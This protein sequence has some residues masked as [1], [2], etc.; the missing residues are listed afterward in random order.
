MASHEEFQVSIPSDT[1][2]GQVV[3]ERIVELLE[4]FEY[5]PR[6]VFG[7]RLAL[8]EALVNSIK[9]GNQMDSSKQVHIGCHIDHEQVVVTIEDEGE[10]FKIE[11]IP[12]P[13][14]EENL[15]KPS[16]RGIMLI[17]AF[18]TN[19]DYNDK[20]NKVSLTKIRGHENDDDD[21]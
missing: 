10:G 20:G 9:H 19:V 16:G 13:T 17:N 12:D 4:R 18:M 5:G 2:E 11:D 8:E 6:E 14:E 7:M 3:Q 15:E 1:A 21:D